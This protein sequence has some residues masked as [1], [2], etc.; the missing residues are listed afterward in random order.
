MDPLWVMT[1]RQCLSV[2]MVT[3]RTGIQPCTSARRCSTQLWMQHLT[4]GVNVYGHSTGWFLCKTCGHDVHQFMCTWTWH[5]RGP[6]AC[7]H[8]RHHPSNQL[9]KKDITY[10]FLERGGE[11][12]RERNINVWLPLAHPLQGT[13]PITQAYAL[14]GNWPGDPLLGRPT[15]SPL[16]HTSQGTKVLF[17]TYLLIL[18]Q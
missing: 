14:T 18:I 6:V 17:I 8:P 13:W 16:S 11:G 10:L 7:K 12:E 5:G 1:C 9:L 4:T 2:H 15:L 3:H